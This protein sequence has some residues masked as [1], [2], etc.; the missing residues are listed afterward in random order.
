MFKMVYPTFCFMPC[1]CVWVCLL[2]AKFPI[3]MLQLELHYTSIFI[4]RKCMFK[5][6][7][8][9]FNTLFWTVSFWKN[10]FCTL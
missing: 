6:S 2:L 9:L 3:H 1:A 4:S 5:V 10:I 7:Y 8:F